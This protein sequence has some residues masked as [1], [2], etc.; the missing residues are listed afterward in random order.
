[1]W[2]SKRITNFLILFFSYISCAFCAE[3]KYPFSEADRD[4]LSALVGKNGKILIEKNIGMKSF[5]LR[6]IIYSNAGSIAMIEEELYKE[7]DRLGDYII[8]KIGKKKVIL[9]KGKELLILKLG[10]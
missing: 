5:E 10:E 4:P 3:Y 2:V 1:M 8:V 6:G 7:N 9:K